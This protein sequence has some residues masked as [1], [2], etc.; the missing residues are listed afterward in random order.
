MSGL[1]SG[2]WHVSGTLAMTGAKE[3]KIGRILGTE[4]PKITQRVKGERESKE[5]ALYKRIRGKA[6]KGQALRGDLAFRKLH[7]GRICKTYI[8][9]TH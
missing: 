3:D 9:K 4:R 7:T 2:H 1:T 5:E 6:L 8:Y